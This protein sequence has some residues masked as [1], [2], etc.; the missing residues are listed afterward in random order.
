MREGECV[1]REKARES[2]S[3]RGRDRENVREREPCVVPIAESHSFK[4][5][6]NTASAE[7]RL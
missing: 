1:E 6:L 5:K 7:N 4:N 2:K 3:E